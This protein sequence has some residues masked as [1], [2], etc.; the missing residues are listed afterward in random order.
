M[1]PKRQIL[2][3]VVAGIMMS[4]TAIDLI[5]NPPFGS[6]TLGLVLGIPGLIAGPGFLWLA[7]SNHQ[8]LKGRSPQDSK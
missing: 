7:W 4:I 5:A 2:L 6:Q 3:A 1:S 8:K